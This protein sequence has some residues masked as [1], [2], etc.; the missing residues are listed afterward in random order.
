MFQLT[1]RIVRLALI[2]CIIIAL[3]SELGSAEGNKLNKLFVN[4]IY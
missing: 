2:I 3:V 4:I 1:P